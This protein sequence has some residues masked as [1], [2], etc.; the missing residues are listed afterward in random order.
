MFTWRCA[1]SCTSTT[2][3]VTRP[4]R[5]AAGATGTRPRGRSRLTTSHFTRLGVVA[6]FTAGE[7]QHKV[8]QSESWWWCGGRGFCV[9]DTHAAAL[10]LGVGGGGFRPT[11]LMAEGERGRSLRRLGVGAGG[12]INMVLSPTAFLSGPPTATRQHTHIHIM[13][14]QIRQ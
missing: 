6:V 4:R 1:T 14:V 5:V 2:T 3:G 12:F 11:F 7:T 10:A 13:S 8:S 9:D